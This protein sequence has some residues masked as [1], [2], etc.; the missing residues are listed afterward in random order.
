MTEF[1]TEEFDLNRK[2]TLS[3][4]DELSL[5]SAP[6]G[7]Q[8]LD[9]IKYRAGLNALDI[10]CGLGF[11]LIELA[12]R[13]GSTSRVFGIDPWKSALERVNLK[14]E[15]LGL[16][17]ASTIDGVAEDI[18]FADEHF[19]LIVSNNGINNVQDLGKTLAECRRVTKRGAQFVFTFNTDGSFEKF[20]QI[21]RE[22]L[23]EFNLGRFNRNIDEHI[24]LKR[25]PLSEFKSRLSANGFRIV[26]V[27][28]DSF[29]Y[30]FA[31]GTA[32]LRHFFIRIAF[33]HPWEE[34]LPQ[35]YRTPVFAAI[36]KR[37]NESALS[38]DGISMN[39]PFVTIDC[40]RI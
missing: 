3:L 8:L 18:P 26:R 21:F 19:D 39:V 1:L 25:K 31:N 34:I 2:E 15:M 10:G 9:A 32:A 14:L 16:R 17:N 6:F 27:I 11:P 7:I 35:I 38:A 37:M 20:Y 36:E 29:D 40:E 5:W 24:Y 23:A 12:M 4:L 33:L 13:L 30:R 22:V 28:E